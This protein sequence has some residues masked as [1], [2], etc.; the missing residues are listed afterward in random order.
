MA[1]TVDDDPAAAELDWQGRYL[2]FYPDELEPRPAGGRSP[3][4]AD[5]TPADGCWW[6]GSATSA[7]SDDGFGVEVANRLAATPLPAGA[8]VV[9][10]GIRGVHLAYELL[11]GYDAL[12][13]VDTVP[14]AKRRVRSPSSS[15]TPTLALARRRRPVVDPHGMNP[16]AVLATL[17]RLGGR[18]DQVYVV[19]CQPACLDEGHRACRRP[20]PRRSTAP[21]NCASSCST[22]IL[23]PAGKG[24]SK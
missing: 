14:W 9:D 22:E 15:R 11:D 20:S 10:F 1:V 16:E 12:I 4:D 8:R 17:D 5:L 19:G 3:I 6:P 7:L 13:L 2:F 18:V 24:T 21:W 23:Q